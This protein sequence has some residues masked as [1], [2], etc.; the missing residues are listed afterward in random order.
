MYVPETTPLSHQQRIFDHTK[1]LATYALFW[2][3]GTGKTKPT[4]DTAAYQ[5]E[6]RKIDA[7]VVVAPERRPPELEERRAPQ[8]PT[9]AAGTETRC[10]SS[11][12]A[13]KAG[14]NGLSKQDEGLAGPQGSGDP[15]A[16]L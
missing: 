15:A 14:N 2:E 16:Q 3:Q 7:L 1:D 11:G 9:Q 13:T 4:I 6:Q 5:Y 10:A 8:A 12:R